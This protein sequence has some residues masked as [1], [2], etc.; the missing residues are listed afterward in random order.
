MATSMGAFAALAFVP[1]LVSLAVFVVTVGATRFVSLGSILT[2]LAFP[3]LVLIF[4][5]QKAVFLSSL[6]IAGLVVFKHAGNI[7]RLLGGT[8]RKLGEKAT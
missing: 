6:A 1:F 7:R 3:F 5:G 2:V 4:H 8:E